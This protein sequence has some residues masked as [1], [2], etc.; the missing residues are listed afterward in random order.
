MNYS[1]RPASGADARAIASIKISGWRNAYEN[2]IASDFLDAMNEAQEALRIHNQINSDPLKHWFVLEDQNG[3]QGFAVCGPARDNHFCNF[4]EIYAI[5]TS[6][7]SQRLGYGSALFQKCLMLLREDGFEIAY[8]WV[9]NKNPYKKFYL[10]IG[11]IWFSEK[12][13]K[14]GQQILD[15]DAYKFSISKQ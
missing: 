8:V 3:I 5:Y 14:I 2:V 10:K 9:L 13:I 7:A 4:G 15:E 11:G 1:I 6:A 12:R